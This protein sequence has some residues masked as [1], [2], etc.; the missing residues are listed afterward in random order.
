LAPNERDVVGRVWSRHIP[1]FDGV[2]IDWQS[3]TDS[4]PARWLVQP[5]RLGELSQWLV[6]EEFERR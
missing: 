5:L 2:I 3:A 6:R 1:G 4:D